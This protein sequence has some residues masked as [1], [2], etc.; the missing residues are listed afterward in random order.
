MK[1]LYAVLPLLL[2]A[3]AGCGTHDGDGNATDE[4]TSMEIDVSGTWVVSEISESGSIRTPVDGTEIVIEFTDD[5][6][7]MIA[8]GCNSMSA[9]FTRTGADLEAGAMAQTEMGCD[10]ARMDQDAWL[11]GLFADPV[12][13]DGTPFTITAGDVVLT[14]VKKETP[15]AALT[16]TTWEL[17]T[18]IEGETA[19]SVGV[20]ASL[21]LTD[22]TNLEFHDGCNSGSGKVAVSSDKLTI[23]LGL[24]TLIGC[25]DELARVAGVMGPFLD[26][27]LTYQIVD[28]RLR[29]SQGSIVLEFTA[30]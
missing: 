18:I 3:V 10:P 24:T 12:T 19:S 5:R 30:R 15:Q 8:A 9:E 29:L 11:A 25:H 27:K 13:L 23:S 20:D 14:L 1:R 6:Q 16:G 26:G 21:K 2:L 17:E 22:K 7:L 4:T 28:D